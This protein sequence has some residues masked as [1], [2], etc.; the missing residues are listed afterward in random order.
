MEYEID[1]QYIFPVKEKKVVNGSL[2]Y[3]INANGYECEVK[4]FESQRGTNPTNITCLFKG[5]KNEK[6]PVFRQ[7]FAV[8]IS[9]IYKVGEVYE[10]KVKNDINA[11]GY[12]EVTD[13]N[14]FIFRL[15]DYGK[16]K[17]YT[18]QIVKAKV[19]SINRIKVEVS[20]VTN[21][22][23]EGLLFMKPE[24]IWKLYELDQLPTRYLNLLFFQAPLLKGAR[25]DYEDGNAMWVIHTIDAIDKHLPDW[26]NAEYPKHKLRSLSAYHCVCLNLL[27]KSEY[28]HNCT[29]D[30]RVKYQKRIATALTHAEDY[31]VA[32]NLMTENREQDYIDDH[33]DRL[34][35]TGYL[36]NPEKTMRVIMSLFTM[37]Q[38]SVQDYIQD[39]FDIISKGHG[40]ERFMTQFRQ[41]FTEM[42]DVYIWN[43]VKEVNLIP[44]IY[45]AVSKQRVEEMVEALAIQ[46]LLLEGVEHEDKNLYRSMLYRFASVIRG[47]ERLINKSY[48][49][50]ISRELWPI[51]YGWAD[52][53]KKD[54]L[55][56][57]LSADV[58]IDSEMIPLL[59]HG[60]NTSIVL[61][62]DSITVS[63][64]SKTKPTKKAYADGITPWNKIQFLLDERMGTKVAPNTSDINKFKLMWNELE[65]SLFALKSAQSSSA[66]KAKKRKASVGDKVNIRIIRQ[67][68]TSKH[69]FFC[70]IEDDY[71]EGDGILDARKIV[72]YNVN[73]QLDLFRDHETQAPFIL[74]ATVEKVNSNGK[75]V[76]GMMKEIENFVYETTETGGDDV[77]AQVTLVE[78]TYYLCV[79]ELGYALSIS[80][81]ETATELKKGDFIWTEI[82]SVKTNGNVS[83]HYRGLA[84]ED[85]KL[86]DGFYSLIHDYANGNLYQENNEETVDEDAILSETYVDV[87][88]IEELIHIIDRHAMTL[89]SDHTAT[90]N[91]LEVAKILSR[92]IQ[93]EELVSYYDKRMNLVRELQKFSELQR[94]PQETL[95]ELLK[96]NEGFVSNYPDIKDRLTQLRIISHLD[97]DWDIDFLWEVA[98]SENDTKCGNLA[99][100][101]LAHNMLKGFN[102]YDQQKAISKRIFQTMDLDMQLPETS[103]VAAEDEVTELKTSMIYPADNKGMRPDE[104][105]QIKELLTVVCSMLNSRGG[106]LYVGVNN[107]GFAVGIEPDFD[108]LSKAPG[109]Y[110]LTQMKDQYDLK[111]RNSV[112]DELGVIANDLI[113]SSFITVEGKTIYKVDVQPSK[114]IIYLDKIAYVRQ[115]T[116]KWPV[117]SKKMAELKAQRERMFSKN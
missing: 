62:K 25:S 93:D 24:D 109:R 38:E 71:Y 105:K 55:C 74:E 87:E 98:K 13:K 117:D 97:K 92:I 47:D 45:N 54:W 89:E 101:V 88:Q 68:P 22:K 81:S 36:Y 14:G 48:L 2:F 57:K 42:L 107:M 43:E 83:A 61:S 6:E 18:N 76:F 85:F 100:L 16:T 110:D 20:L 77:L 115:S 59:F 19:K 96:E 17:I 94:I 75:L 79:T 102:A 84:D 1:K 46:L 65:R 106:T 41:A 30:E 53:E 10:F 103:F 95:D 40:N 7:D 56:A 114:E 3:V 51:E 70:K 37:R 72:H 113:S 50:L 116:S 104:K 12:Y 15:V 44:K 86:S 39:I 58:K 27:E 29:E 34:K 49:S 35:N 80:K 11:F 23:T 63:P 28:L 21:K 52:L 67:N 26:L 33:L 73:F 69:E 9:Q 31:I 5:Y 99:R 112:H 60:N 66:S 82:E 78:P 91:Y 32:L 90:Y 4:A 64:I 8:L 108:Y 111:F